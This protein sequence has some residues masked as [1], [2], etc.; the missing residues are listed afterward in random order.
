VKS[1]VNALD[2]K[3][4][5]YIS[6]LETKIAENHYSTL[7]WMIGTLIAFSGIIFA[8]IQLLKIKF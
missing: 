2:K 1:Q 8:T 7:R 6:R 3:I 5:I 4:E